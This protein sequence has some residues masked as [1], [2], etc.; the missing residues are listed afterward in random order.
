MLLTCLM[1]VAAFAGKEQLYVL[2]Q[3]FEE[4]IPADWTQEYLTSYQ[5][6]WTVE[7]A[8]EA[9][10][11]KVSFDGSKYLALRNGLGRDW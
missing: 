6:P 10:F 2:H 8:A 4:G 7:N 9:T 1:T 11:P 3:G 5:Q